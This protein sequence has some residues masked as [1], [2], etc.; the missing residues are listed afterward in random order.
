V[1]FVNCHSCKTLMHVHPIDDEDFNKR[2]V[3]GDEPIYCRTCWKEKL[4]TEETSHE[5]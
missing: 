3:E 5:H 4:N 2:Y 1:P